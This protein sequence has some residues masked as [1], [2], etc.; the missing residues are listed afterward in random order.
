MKLFRKLHRKIQKFFLL[1]ELH[2][3]EQELAYLR[4]FGKPIGWDNE[5]WPEVVKVKM[6]I[7]KTIYKLQVILAQDAYDN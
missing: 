1:R 7:Q 3:R 5:T 4:T 6:Q 2:L